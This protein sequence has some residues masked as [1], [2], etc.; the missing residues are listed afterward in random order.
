MKS[1]EGFEG[2]SLFE[3]MPDIL[4]NHEGDEERPKKKKRKLITSQENN[5]S[6]QDLSII[7]VPTLY[8]ECCPKS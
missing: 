3:F 7:K 6:N 1:F 5:S 8:K 2:F 4:D